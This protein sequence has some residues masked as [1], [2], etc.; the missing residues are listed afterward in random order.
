MAGPMLFDD[1][2]SDGRLRLAQALQLLAEDGILFG[3]SSWKYQGW[4]GQIYSGEK[5]ISRGRFSKKRFEETCLREYAGIF[6]VVCG[7]FSFYQFPSEDYWRRLF[8]SAPGHLKFAFKVP[9]ELTVKQFPSHARYGAR[10]GVVNEN[11]LNLQ[12]C[13]AAFARPLLPY[14]ERISALIFEFGTFARRTLSGVE[15][16]LERLDPFLASLPEEFRYSVEIRNPEFLG[17]EYFECLRSHRVAHVFNAWT[18]MPELSSQIAL[19][20]A[21]TAD[22]SV[23]RALLRHGRSY[24]DAV[25]RFSPY[26]RVQEED[27]GARQAMRDI[28]RRARQQRQQAVI[29][30]NNRLEGN[31]PATIQAVVEGM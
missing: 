12:L 27:P 2:L 19:P 15:E 30:V 3:T 25:Q 16:F 20:G 13:D 6:P 5:Y 21:F 23:T 28:V 17:P 1:P 18:R 4:I 10:G 8:A 26:E 11:F 7:D 14:R 24:E 22:F 29:F 31:A 9:E